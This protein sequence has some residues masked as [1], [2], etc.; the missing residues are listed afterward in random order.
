VYESVNV[1]G[2]N[3]Y[4]NFLHFDGLH[5]RQRKN[6]LLLVYIFLIASGVGRQKE[7]DHWEDQGVGGWTILECILER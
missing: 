4:I 7:R 3:Q 1:S 2:S 5:T 6:E